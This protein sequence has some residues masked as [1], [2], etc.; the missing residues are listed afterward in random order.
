[1]HFIYNDTEGTGKPR[2]RGFSNVTPYHKLNA[3]QFYLN[4]FANL[5]Y[6]EFISS[7]SETS[8]LEKLQ[9]TKEIAICNKKLDYWRKHPNWDK[10]IV[11]H[12]QHRLK[13]AWQAPQSCAENMRRSR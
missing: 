13:A 3:T 12:E 10:T 4:H 5:L 1:M 6:L 11:E 8:T 2:N 7:H 9:A